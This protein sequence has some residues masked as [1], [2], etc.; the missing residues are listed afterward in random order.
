MG[1]SPRSFS[2]DEDLDNLLSEREDI[3]A[4]AVVN[5]L[6][7]EYVAGGKGTEAALEARVQQLDEEIA[8][9]EQDLQQ[10][11]R[12]RDRV[13]ERLDERESQLTAVVDEAVSKIAERPG[14][15]EQRKKPDG[16]LWRDEVTADNLR[17]QKWA[18]EA[19][20]PVDRLISEL[21]ARL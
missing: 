17:V 6:L 9:T 8:Q 21:E 18:S 3:N 12:E 14:P 20:V 5:S 4:S 1:K 15:R 13:T 7:R 2:I 16:G 11:K 19:G 10:L